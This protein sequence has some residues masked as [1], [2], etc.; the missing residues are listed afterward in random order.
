MFTTFSIFLILTNRKQ[1]MDLIAGEGNSCRSG[2][3]CVKTIVGLLS[4]PPY[5]NYAD[6]KCTKDRHG[7]ESRGSLR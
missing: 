4:H 6:D 2:S 1:R 3:Y 7:I 5:C